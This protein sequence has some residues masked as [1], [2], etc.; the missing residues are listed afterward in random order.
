MGRKPHGGGE[1]GRKGGAGPEPRIDVWRLCSPLGG[2]SS[3][4]LGGSRIPSPRYAG[5]AA[6]NANSASTG[7]CSLSFFVSHSRT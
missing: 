4:P 7:A 6:F 5:S 2:K 3:K 1:E